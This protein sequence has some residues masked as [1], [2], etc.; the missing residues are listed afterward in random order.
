MTEI[1][2]IADQLERAL[3]GDPWY[4]PSLAAVLQGVDEASANR[5]A[6][7]AVHSIHEIVLHIASWQ[8]EVAR[9]L[10]DGVAREPADGDWP[11]P[12]RW[13][14]ALDSLEASSQELRDAIRVLPEE[15]LTQPVGEER[16]PP[17]GSGVSFYVMLHGIVQHTL[18]HT[19]QISLLRRA[20]G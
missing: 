18:A 4:G 2:R 14:A 15:R 12:G 5:R 20:L 13:Q 17:L 16:D 7:P 6:A 19:A 9:R 8:R 10:R 11:T 1:E 3:G